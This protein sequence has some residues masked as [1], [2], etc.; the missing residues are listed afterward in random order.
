MSKSGRHYGKWDKIRYSLRSIERHAPWVDKVWI[1]GDRPSFMSDDKSVIEHVPEEYLAHVL[2]IAPPVQNMFLLLVLS[3]FIPE[4]SFEFVLFS[5][6]FFLLRDFPL[7]EARK[8][9]YL[10][11]LTMNRIEAP[12]REGLWSESLW[13]TRDLLIRLGYEAFNFEIHAPTFFTKKRVL[14]AYRDFRYFV[15][16]DRWQ[17]M[18]GIS[19]ILNHALKHEK[20]GPTPPLVSIEKEA[21]RGGFWGAPPASYQALLRELDGKAFMNFN[22]R[23]FGPLIA[24]F[25]QER[26]PKPSRYEKA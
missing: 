12:R 19:A 3:S 14:E 20:N 23:A 24:R 7:E 11:D 4:L 18:M 10:E 21:S 16:E 2:D 8:D 15:T 5:D 13:R 9:R 6:D 22:D 26:Y 25:L 1:F 17:G